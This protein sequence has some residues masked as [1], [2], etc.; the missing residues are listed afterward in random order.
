MVGSLYGVKLVRV[1]TAVSQA[2]VQ[3]ESLAVS[4]PIKHNIGLNLEAKSQK[5]LQFART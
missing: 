5:P 3:V 1:Q 4:L 2:E